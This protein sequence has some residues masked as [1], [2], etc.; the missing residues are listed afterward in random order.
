MSTHDPQSFAQPASSH[1][2]RITTVTNASTRQPGRQLSPSQNCLGDSIT[3]KLNVLSEHCP[4]ITLPYLPPCIFASLFPSVF[5]AGP[6]RQQQGQHNAPRC[7]HVFT[8]ISAAEPLRGSKGDTIPS[9]YSPPRPSGDQQST[10]ITPG[11]GQKRR[12]PGTT[13]LCADGN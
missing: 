7:H 12:K 2:Q 10:S 6:P 11:G 1:T 5:V 8:S 3:N 9:S 4:Y 13:H